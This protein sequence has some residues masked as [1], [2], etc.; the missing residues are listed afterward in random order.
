[1]IPFTN[2]QVLIT[3]GAH[4]GL[5]MSVAVHSTRLGQALGGARL[6]HYDSWTDA[7]ADALWLS[8]AMTLKNAAAGLNRGGGESV[9]YLRLGTVLTD[10][11]KR[12]AMLDL[13]EAIDSVGGA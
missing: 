3:T 1:M 12:D 13:G 9:I 5:I 2:E 10:A 11:Q 4:S 8:A 6:W 7:V